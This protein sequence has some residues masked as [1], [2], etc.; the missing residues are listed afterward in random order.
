M[1]QFDEAGTQETTGAGPSGSVAG[2][3]TTAEP[4]LETRLV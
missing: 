1:A 4:S 2:K 3:G